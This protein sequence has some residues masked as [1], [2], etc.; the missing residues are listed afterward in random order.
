MMEFRRH[1]FDGTSIKALER[2]T[3][4]SSGSLYNSFGDKNAIFIKTLARYNRVIV[5]QRIDEHLTR[6]QPAAGLRSFFL[7]LLDEPDDD[8]I[9]CLLTNSAIEFGGGDS[10]ASA[11]VTA[12]FEL[13][14]KAFMATA[15]RLFPHSRSIK[16]KALKLLALYQGVLVLFR[17]G[18]P[19][20]KLAAMI[21]H[22]LDRMLGEDNV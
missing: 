18:H 10:M 20:Q 16:E 3:G 7:S 2:A 14:E 1:G 15:V 6:K 9:G 4:L 8:I 19:K 5:A 13:Q 12:G 21:T 17:S 22:E 11:G